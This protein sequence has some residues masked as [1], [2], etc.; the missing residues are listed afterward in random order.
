[1]ESI[2]HGL[3]HEKLSLRVAYAFL[4]FFILLAI[5]YSFGFFFLPEGF[6]KTLPFPALTFFEDKRSFWSLFTQTLGYNL[7]A[8]LIIVG[9]NHFRVR[10][11]AFGYLPL[12]TN[13]VLMGLF[14]GTNSFSGGISTYTSEGWIM[15]LRI[16]FLEFSAYILVCATT[17]ELAMFHADRWRGEQF[18]RIRR[19]GEVSLSAQESVVI[20]FALGLLSIAAFNEWRHVGW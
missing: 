20:L 13:T 17:V 3:G 9:C 5:T 19:F 7:L 14:A 10:R 1:M 11:C 18:K 8:L 15:F 2:L 4:Y 12:Y 16:G 6:M